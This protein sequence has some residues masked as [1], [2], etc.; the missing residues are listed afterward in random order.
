MFGE[1]ATS[2]AKFY[3]Y[4]TVTTLISENSALIILLV[5]FVCVTLVF[6]RLSNHQFPRQGRDPVKT[7]IFKVMI[8]FMICAFIF[9]GG[10]TVFYEKKKLEGSGL[11]IPPALSVRVV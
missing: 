8:V 6:L 1:I 11:N 10:F 5:A 7:W 4:R 3:G 9:I 2:I